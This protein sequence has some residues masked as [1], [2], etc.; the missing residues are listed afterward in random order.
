MFTPRG[1]PLFS[2]QLI[3]RGSLVCGDCTW[4]VQKI[5]CKHF[6]YIMLFNPRTTFYVT[7]T[8]IPPTFQMGKLR[9]RVAEGY[10]LGPLVGWD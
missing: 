9:H 3:S 8:P 7:A 4:W 2:L 1:P 5:E 10:Y 6:L